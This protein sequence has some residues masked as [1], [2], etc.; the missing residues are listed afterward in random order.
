MGIPGGNRSNIIHFEIRPHRGYSARNHPD[1][2]N[3]SKDESIWK[4]TFLAIPAVLGQSVWAVFASNF[5]V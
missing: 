3:N 4:L 5:L 1:G 2:I